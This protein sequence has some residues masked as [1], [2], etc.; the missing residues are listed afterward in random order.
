VPVAAPPLGARAAARVLGVLGETIS[1]PL[2]D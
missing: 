2:D 1:Q